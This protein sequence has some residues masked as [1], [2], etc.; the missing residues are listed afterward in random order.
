MTLAE[1]IALRERLQHDFDLMKP[2]VLTPE[3]RCVS[4]GSGKTSGD[5]FWL[6]GE[7]Y[8]NDCFLLEK[9]KFEN[10]LH[11]HSGLGVDRSYRDDLMNPWQENAFRILEDG[12]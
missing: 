7:R 2:T 11:D 8:C 4:C 9:A 3:N 5:A 1:Y 6:N 10:R 12:A